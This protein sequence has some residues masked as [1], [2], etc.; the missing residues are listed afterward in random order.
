MFKAF[1]KGEM[2]NYF[3]FFRRNW[4]D[5]HMFPRLRRRI[6]DETAWIRGD[7]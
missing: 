3:E 1:L 4:W 6:Q 2:A 7:W 5:K